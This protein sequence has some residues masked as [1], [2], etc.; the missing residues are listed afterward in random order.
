MN[1]TEFEH[2]N[3]QQQPPLIGSEIRF[4]RG[5]LLWWYSRGL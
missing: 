4:K 1:K 2:Y 5:F 3:A